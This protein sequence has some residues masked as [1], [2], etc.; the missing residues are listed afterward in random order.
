MINPCHVVGFKTTVY[1]AQNK[2]KGADVAVSINHVAFLTNIF[3]K[4][5]SLPTS[6]IFVSGTSKSVSYFQEFSCI[7]AILRI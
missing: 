5:I 2:I 1:F 7:T 6:T 4:L 3:S